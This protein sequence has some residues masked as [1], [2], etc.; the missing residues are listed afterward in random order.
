MTTSND[1]TPR[2]PRPP[3]PALPPT[4]AEAEAKAIEVDLAMLADKR[5]DGYGRR[6]VDRALL[7]QIQQAHRD[8]ET[9]T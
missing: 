8:G 2:S 5:V 9:W 4:Q 7:A 1:L 6:D 3:R